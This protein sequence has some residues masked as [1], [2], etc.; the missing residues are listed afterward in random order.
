[1]ID[2]WWD[3]C[4]WNENAKFYGLIR[5]TSCTEHDIHLF[6]RV[7]ISCEIMIIYYD[8]VF[9]ITR[10]FASDVLLIDNQNSKGVEVLFYN[11]KI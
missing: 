1:M 4:E 8:F 6:Q 10:M 9:L 3:V 2:G 11:W 5:E 7:R